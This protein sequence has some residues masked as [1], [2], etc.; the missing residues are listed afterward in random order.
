MDE[1]YEKL[2]KRF[3]FY[4]VSRAFGLMTLELALVEA[5]D[6]EICRYTKSLFA[7]LFKL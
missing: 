2:P 7:L 5:S 6:I 3:V 4:V 1:E